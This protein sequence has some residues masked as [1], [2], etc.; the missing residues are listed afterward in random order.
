MLNQNRY[1]FS[2][3]K[4]Q[5]LAS[6]IKEEANGDAKIDKDDDFLDIS[7]TELIRASQAVESQLKFT[8]NVH[9]ATS[10]AITIFSQFTQSANDKPNLA[11][12]HLDHREA[13]DGLKQEIRQL[14][15]T[16][17]QKDGEVKIL[18]D[19]LK[20]LEQEMQKMR[21]EKIDLIK[22]LQQ[23]QDETKRNF[24][25]QIEYKELENQ[26]KSQEIVELTMKY[27]VLESS[28]KKNPNTVILA[29]SNSIVNQK[30]QQAKSAPLKRSAQYTS[31]TENESPDMKRFLSSNRCSRQT[32][33]VTSATKCWKRSCEL[34]V[35]SPGLRPSNDSVLVYKLTEKISNLSCCPKEILFDKTNK[36]FV[37]KIK[38]LNCFLKNLFL[39][40]IDVINVETSDFIFSKLNEQLLKLFNLN[41]ISCDSWQQID[42]ICI[43]FESLYR[44]FLIRYHLQI[45][46][47]NLNQASLLK[48]NFVSLVK[49]FLNLLNINLSTNKHI[50]YLV[51]M[52]IFNVVLDMFNCVLYSLTCIKNDS[53]KLDH[54][55]NLVQSFHCESNENKASLEPNVTDEN[56]NCIFQLIFDKISVFFT[57]TLHFLDQNEKLKSQNESS[58][59]ESNQFEIITTIGE[60]V[61]NSKIDFKLEN[62]ISEN[63]L[64]N[65]SLSEADDILQSQMD[66]APVQ[67]EP[68]VQQVPETAIQ[69]K[70]LEKPVTTDNLK[71]ECFYKLIHFIYNYEIVQSLT[72]NKVKS[73][74]DNEEK[75]NETNKLETSSKKRKINQS[76]SS[77]ECQH[78]KPFSD[79][80]ICFKN[81]LNSL[82]S[83]LDYLFGEKDFYS[84]NSQQCLSNC[85]IYLNN[86]LDQEQ[87]DHLLFA[88]GLNVFLTMANI[89]K[90]R[91]D[92]DEIKLGF[93]NSVMDDY[94]TKNFLTLIK[95]AE[96]NFV[97]SVEEKMEI[98]QTK[99]NRQNNLINSLNSL[100]SLFKS[101]VEEYF[102]FTK[103]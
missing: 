14:K 63:Y 57:E 79:T 24:Q 50:I 20:R 101:C 8:N 13:E 46:S 38:N 17:M 76:L 1:R 54:F 65:S 25:K 59:S 80:C 7:D 60:E 6:N 11:N 58:K 29:P 5:N 67:H 102:D 12:A 92:I 44:L 40:K 85:S 55:L 37:K 86:E 52:N 34:D 19:K 78:K 15:N 10:N 87:N 33:N 53:K 68:K 45:D 43:L 61:K 75:I 77:L 28:V 26:F 100:K 9:H 89:D 95:I 16:N 56:E 22:K 21:T 2:L 47:N 88:I 62:K 74:T 30:I 84:G 91:K 70:S 4:P 94:K 71:L 64:L 73:G 90:L 31:D 93:I 98:D 48:D 36:D 23:Q 27:K 97:K 35:K 18:R 32:K 42:T 41:E 69:V 81:I 3:N 49:Q 83:S 72:L 66:T 99:K 39:V 51:N 82:L 103:N 96:S